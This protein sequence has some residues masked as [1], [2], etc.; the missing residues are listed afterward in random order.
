[1][2]PLQAQALLLAFYSDWRSRILSIA[3]HEYLLLGN[4]SNYEA[5]NAHVSSLSLSSYTQYADADS[6]LSR[7]KPRANA[8][9]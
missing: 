6:K 8:R 2:S 4:D 3:K 7:Q 1:M 5:F 9:M